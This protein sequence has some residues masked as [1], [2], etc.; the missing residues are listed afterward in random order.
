MCLSARA[1]ALNE[2]FKSCRILCTAHITLSELSCLVSSL[3]KWKHGKTQHL[4][5]NWSGKP[6]EYSFACCACL[7]SFCTYLVSAF[8]AYST[9][10]SENFSNL[11]R[12]DVY[13]IVHQN[14][15]LIVIIH[16]S[17]SMTFIKR[18]SPTNSSTTRCT[19]GS[20]QYNK[21]THSIYQR[22]NMRQ[23]EGNDSCT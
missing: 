16:I 21:Q 1:R 3:R 11:L 10:F 6:S 22:Q 7:Q 15:Y 14:V 8:P 9:S 5:G 19:Y 12:W 17:S 2:L 23:K 13:W 18:N 20:K 4:S